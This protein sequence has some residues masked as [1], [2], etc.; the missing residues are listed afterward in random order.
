MAVDEITAGSAENALASNE[1]VVICFYAPWSEA[2]RE[3][4]QTFV[5]ASEAYP[6]VS[7]GRCNAEIA[8][9]L[10]RELSITEVPT[11]VLFRE[12]VA[13]ERISGIVPVEQLGQLLEHVRAL[14]MAHVHDHSSDNHVCRCG[15]RKAKAEPQPAETEASEAP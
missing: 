14:D 3:H 6:D 8:P 11:L 1:I 10:V 2:Y 12:Q 7:F 15:R 4:E 9:R 5:A 13:V